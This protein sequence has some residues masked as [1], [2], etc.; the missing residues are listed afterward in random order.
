[1]KLLGIIIMIICA[2]WSSSLYWGNIDLTTRR[3]MITYPWQTIAIY[4]MLFIGA[5]L[6][7][8]EK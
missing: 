4:I 5:W 6:F 8:K 7:I 1:M 2:I 3:V